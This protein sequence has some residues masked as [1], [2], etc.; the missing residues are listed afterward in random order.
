LERLEDRLA[1]ATISW[2][3]DADGF[4][5]VASNWDLGHVPAPGDDVVINRPNAN[6][7]I[8]FRSGTADLNSL[9]STEALT[10]SGGT[11]NLAT[12]SS[13]SAAFSLSGG[14]L[15]GTGTV[16]VTGAMTWTGGTMVG[17]GTTRIA[18][19]ATLD[20]GGTQGVVIGDTRQLRNDGTVTVSGAS[21]NP[22]GNPVITN[23]GLFDFRSDGGVVNT[24]GAFIN[25]GTL[26]KSAGTG[27]SLLE[28]DVSNAGA[29][30][31][32][33]GTLSLMGRGA[34]TST[35]TFAVGFEALLAF[36]LVGGSET[37]TAASSVSGAGSV[38]FSGGTVTVNGAYA[39]TGL[40]TFSG[41]EADFN[42]DASISRLQLN[43]GTLGGTGTVTVTGLAAW[44]G[45]TMAGAGTTRIAAGASL[46][47]GG[48]GFPTIA[49]PRQLRNDGTV[50]VI[51]AGFAAQSGSAPVITNTGLFD[52][53]S[54]GGLSNSGTFTNTG[55]LRNS[56]GGSFL[57]WDLG[58]AGTVEVLGGALRL[59]GRGAATSPGVFQ[60][61]SGA[62]LEFA[63][64]GG[65]E[66]L[67]PASSVSG[68][69]NVSFVNGTVSINGAYAVSGLTTFNGAFAE[70]DF[71]VDVSILNLQF[72]A[73][74]LA[75]TGTVTVT[76]TLNWTGGSMRGA[77]S[78]R[79]AAGA[80]LDVSGAGQKDLLDSRRLT[81]DG[82]ITWSGTGP[83]TTGGNSTAV[84]TNNGLF[85]VRVAANLANN[86]I[87]FV[88]NGIL[89]IAAA[90]SGTTRF[91]FDLGNAGTVEVLGG[92][93][94]LVGIFGTPTSTGAFRVSTGTTLEFDLS[95]GS[96]TLTAA[97]SI[98]GAG[99]VTFISGTVS[100][101]GAYAVSGLTTLGGSFATADFNTD[102]SLPHV[103]FNA[104]TLGGTGTVTVTGAM[105]W[106]AGDMAGAGTTRIAA[107]A[108]LDVGGTQFVTFRDT[109]QLR[110]D[111]TATVS[112]AGINPQGSPVI[113]NAGLFDFRSDGGVVNT[114]GS[115]TNTGTL[116]KSAGTGTSSLFQ[117]LSNSG[118]VEV[119]AGTLAVRGTLTNYSATTKTLTGGTYAVRGNAT[120]QFN[121][122]DIQTNAAALVLD[123]PAS[124][125]TDTANADA[126][127][128]F[129]TNAAGGSFTVQNGRNFTAAGAV[130]NS[131]G[132]TVGAGSTFTAAA[133][134]QAGTGA[135]TVGIGGPPGSGQVGT[136]NTAGPLTL[137]GTFTVNLVNGFGPS[138]GQSFQVMTFAGLTGNFATF[139][140]LKVGGVQVFSF[141]LNPI[142]LI[143]QTVTSLADLE[144]DSMNLT[145]FGKLGENVSIPYS[146]RNLSA[147]VAATGSWFDSFYLS[148]DDKLDAGDLLIGRVHHVGDVGPKDSY[149]EVLTAPLPGTLE[150]PYRVIL[151][152]DSRG[153]VPDSDRTNNV[154]VS[155]NV[156]QLQ[157]ETLD[158][159]TRVTGTLADGQDR[160]FRLEMPAG[161]EVQVTA[162][163]PAA[164]Q[165][166]LFVRR[167][168]LPSRTQF[169]EAATG[170]DVRQQN[171]VL[172][173]SG[174]TFYVLL[175]GLPAAGS[176]QPFDLIAQQGTF[177]VIG[178]APAQGSN[179]GTA[180]ITVFGAGFTPKTVVGLTAGGVNRP[181]KNVI[182]QSSQ[183][184]FAT[185]DLT[186][187]T[188]G[189]YEIHLQDGDRQ[190][191]A[192]QPFTVTTGNP[193]HLD[194]FVNA[195]SRILRFRVG[196][197]NVEYVNAGDTD[198]PG[199]TLQ[200]ASSEARFGSAIA[201]G[202]LNT[203]A[204]DFT[205]TLTSPAGAGG[206]LAPGGD[207]FFF[208]N[209]TSIVPEPGNIEVFPTPLRFNVSTPTQTPLNL[210]FLK[211]MLRPALLPPDAWDA[212]FANFVARIGD[213]VESLQSAMNEAAAY[214]NELGED[215]SDPN[216]VIAFLL[217]LADNAIPG[218]TLA[219][220]TDATAPAPGLSLS[221]SRVYQQPIS[222]RYQLG[223]FGRGWMTPYDMTLQADSSGRFVLY[224]PGGTSSFQPD[225]GT[226]LQAHG[227]FGD[228]GVLVGAAADPFGHLTGP[229]TLHEVDGTEYRFEADG[230]LHQIRDP[231]G[232]TIT[233]NY[234]DGLLTSLVHSDGDQFKLD[235]NAQGRVIR[236]TDQAGRVTNY[237]YDAAGEH[238]LH[239][240]GPFGFE[241]YV[242]ETGTGAA[243]EHALKTIT[244]R[245]GTHVFYTYDDQGQLAHVE[246]DGG[247]QPLTIGYGPGGTVFFT[248]VSGAS[249]TIQFDAFGQPSQVLDPLNR[250]GVHTYDANHNPAGDR[251]PDGLSMTYQFNDLGL[252][253]SATDPTG[254]GVAQTFAP[255]QTLA[256]GDGGQL[257]TAQR[258]S[259]LTDQLGAVTRYAY[260]PQGNLLTLTY[261]DGSTEQFGYDAAG[262]VTQYRNRNGQLLR[263]TYDA[264][265]ELL[266]RDHADGTHED[267]TY[268]SGG[269]LLTAGDAH[270]TT[271]YKYDTADN[272][273]RVTYP[274]GRFLAYTY[275]A[276]QRLVSRTDQSG[277]TLHYTYDAVGRLA[278]LSDGADNLLAHYA[279]DSVGRLSRED[280]G[281]GT[282]TTYEFDV[283][284][285]LLHLVN[286][287]PGGSINSKF[288]YTYDDLGRRI[289]MA[290]L[291]GGWTYEYDALGQLTHAV[292]ASTNP[293]IPNQDLRY[294]Y[295][296][297]GNRTSTTVNGVTTP[298]GV[299]NL[300]QYT[301][302]GTVSYSYDANGNRIETL[303]GPNV[304]TYRFDD[305][306]RLVGVTTPTDTWTYEYDAL[307][308]RVATVHNGQRSEYLLDPT[309]LGDVAGEYDGS[310]GLVAS[311]A[312]GLGLEA[313]VGTDG[314]PAFY[315]FDAT[316]STAG[317]SGAD[318]NYV[319]AYSYLPFGEAL[320]APREAVANPFTYVGQFGVM[321]EGNGLDFMRA[322]F[323]S[324]AD[325]RF[326]NQ[327]P[328]RV[329]GGLN[330]YRYVSNH[331][332]Q[333]IDPSGLA[334]EL[335][336]INGVAYLKTAIDSVLVSAAGSPQLAA[337][338]AAKTVVTGPRPLPPL[339]GPPAPPLPPGPVQAVV[340][341]WSSGYLGITTRTAGNAVRLG[342]RGF[343]SAPLMRLNAAVTAFMVGWAI[344]RWADR[345]YHLGE[346]PLSFWGNLLADLLERFTD[347]PEASGFTGQVRSFDPNDLSGPAGFGDNHFVAR[348]QSLDYTIHFENLATATAPAQKV[349]VTQQLDPDLDFSTFELGDLGFG[350]MVIHVPA[351]R[352]SFQTRVDARAT[353]GVFVDVTADL[354]PVTGLAIWTFTSADPT[355]FD[356]PADPETGFLPPNKTGPQGEGFVSYRVRARGASSTGTR[357]DAQARVVF[358]D[359]ALID[360]PASFNTVDAGDPTSSVSA[361]PAVTRTAS[362]TVSW[363]GSDDAGGSGIGLFDVFVSDNGGAF[364]PFLTSTPLTSATFTGQFGHTYGFYSVATDNVGHREVTPAAAQATTT[365]VQDVMA[366]AWPAGNSLQAADVQ[367]TSVT[368]TWTPAQDD[369]GVI[370]YRVFQG[371]MLVATTDAGTLTAQVS[372]LQP[373]TAYTFHVEA[374]D[375]AGNQSTTGPA[376]TLTTAAPLLTDPLTAFVTQLYRDVLGRDPEAGGLTLWVQAFQ[377]DTTRAQVAQAVWESPEHRGLEVDQFYATY[378]HRAADALGRAFW[379][380]QLLGGVSETDTAALFLT[381]E[382]YTLAHPNTAAFV[383]GVYADVLGRTPDALGLV[384]WPPLTDQ[385]TGGRLATARG[386][387]TSV[388][389]EGRILDGFYAAYLHRAANAAGRQDWLAV[390]QSGRLT[391]AQVAEAFLASDE[392]L[393]RG[394]AR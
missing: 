171:L 306:D 267:F 377:G 69:G 334:G 300:D 207:G 283:A 136:L 364:T 28:M 174:G 133:Y 144:A 294:A 70:A 293:A 289:G 231:N 4:W 99:N 320:A 138:A 3:T 92:T 236:L 197:L 229:A 368:L 206:V 109:R 168:D 192:P 137:D 357:L 209:F 159:G 38:T 272:L 221:L 211:T 261:A 284:G 258:L 392:Y 215:A 141:A 330:L 188:P 331:P 238:L 318:G 122:A 282:F 226:S 341:R 19:G 107:G 106:T 310:G 337:F 88:N 223:E 255:A 382:E 94:R 240:D 196:A 299:N 214:L 80:S 311:F 380:D 20:I 347:P 179:A 82:T 367:T 271:T 24:G 135:L 378:L 246:Q 154:L 327:D 182:F 26:R 100:V 250:L 1:P 16:A 160:Y 119:L 305:Q 170:F 130:S 172:S 336:F 105:T 295:D 116:R 351:G 205:T 101:N 151:V 344:G 388:E 124:Q 87:P 161:A 290:T 13:L 308:N 217:Q 287:A 22:Q 366:P 227:L 329:Q 11:L 127:A 166:Q 85:E 52:L 274:N 147:T 219:A 78:S 115:F 139:N 385:G 354:N 307:G 72:N 241:N 332:T 361:L 298:Y 386:V 373:G 98:T 195:P 359:N 17:A 120:L 365:V 286:H 370:G 132:L 352:S 34:A 53:Q 7:T 225:G 264:R 2:N 173:G 216:L 319:D 275:D 6:P 23:A 128:H 58:N 5:D 187:L 60:V 118:T 181:A 342:P 387:L 251:L 296:A 158:L 47:V 383:N 333:D 68:A 175:H 74:S 362:F 335:V 50:T 31:V 253:T 29:V 348:Q 191:T 314:R 59:Q 202:L 66:T 304:T 65:S 131:G 213:T 263:Y 64:L 356:L 96:Q 228:P 345:E 266:R 322:R 42:A 143:L 242:Y 323:Y 156:I 247:A 190:A 62:F 349:V 157:L 199:V 75:G 324:P 153:L 243:R 321:Q 212:I 276:L 125:I 224:W 239:V 381:S 259:N 184:L 369:V 126:L 155:P 180:T 14:T 123:G 232:N 86:D 256:L 355:T 8:T 21:L 234:T 129:A 41:G 9:Q 112:G 220:S 374:V 134:T 249:S 278:Q 178:A 312:Q 201:P 375:A 288:D 51:E 33:S 55:T 56:I 97:S 358:D 268:D 292:F 230:K 363:G 189:P 281:N 90:A 317:L 371:T 146:V 43:S 252:P 210:E 93:L 376:L 89:R 165:G 340:T 18:A 177:A 372:G 111:G 185:F 193:G 384:T 346:A 200:L 270:G 257:P 237:A 233:L 350:G 245:D 36:A 46:V 48:T 391:P 169:D 285:Q 204:L 61:S 186:G 183:L 140:G 81:N 76:G 244:I 235:Y 301:A 54:N 25:T 27:T 167:G 12:D 39:V 145:G 71:N 390:L 15:G 117:S 303:D 260:D 328:I 142:H 316:G 265:G 37:L 360:T 83:L 353:L 110:N 394:G 49:G 309:G 102:V 162:N 279:Y 63:L 262:N 218:G 95:D 10:L 164:M 84:L 203:P 393:S 339:A 297:A 121:D 379:I 302:V 67:T 148:A 277:F 338:E 30:E 57:D 44:T 280:H 152:C 326:I 176:G 113:T 248:D 73:G 269:N 313:R 315:D 40:T 104:G 35:G 149:L 77:G 45:G 343:I 325:G 108:T 32:Q 389:T 273:T 198:L 79:I 150:G 291:D 222:R 163:L 114:G 254:H 194:V 91:T 208:T 103:Q